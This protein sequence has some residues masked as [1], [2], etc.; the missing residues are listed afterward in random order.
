VSPAAQQVTLEPQV[1]SPMDGGRL[2]CGPR[3]GQRVAAGWR[4][5]GLDDTAVRVVAPPLGGGYGGKNHAKLEPVAAAVARIVGRPVRLANRRAEEFVTTTKHPA[6]IWIE[7]GVD[8][9]ARFTFRRARIRWSAGAYAHSSPA[10][11]RAG[12]LVVCGPYQVP[13]A[14]DDR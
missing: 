5:F 10:V 11:L 7:S 1:A 9:D 2:G 6:R 12:A 14:G 3:P 4:V 8:A 13:A